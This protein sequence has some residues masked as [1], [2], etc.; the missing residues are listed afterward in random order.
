MKPSLRCRQDAWT[1]KSCA[2][3]RAQGLSARLLG[4]DPKKWLQEQQGQEPTGQSTAAWGAGRTLRKGRDETEGSGM[5]GHS[6]SQA[7]RHLPAGE[8]GATGG[9]SQGSPI[10]PLMS[11][12]IPWPQR[13]KTR[14]QPGP[15]RKPEIPPGRRCWRGEEGMG[16]S[17][18][19]VPSFDSGALL[20]LEPSPL[21][22]LAS[23]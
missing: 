21:P 20:T 22:G 1:H 2:H 8:V 6:G 18:L 23:N 16:P 10:Y 7:Q 5:R 19:Y 4:Q 11:G 9:P 15:A 17:R 12:R 14:A 13:R 3:S